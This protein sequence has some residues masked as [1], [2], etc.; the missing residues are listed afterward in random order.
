ME[1]EKSVSKEEKFSLEAGLKTMEL[2]TQIAVARER[3]DQGRATLSQG[4]RARP[5][6]CNQHGELR[7]LRGA[8]AQG[9]RRGRA[10]LS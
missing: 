3:N 6:R 7:K 4:T 5:R 8:G 2:V 10:T 1:G 9:L